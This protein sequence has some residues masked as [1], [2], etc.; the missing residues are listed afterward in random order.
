MLF[1]WLIY[2]NNTAELIRE[3]KKGMFV[4]DLSLYIADEDRE[5]AV[6]RLNE[7]LQRIY[8]WSIVNHMM[9][10]HEK[11]HVIDTGQGSRRMKD[12]NLKQVLFG[13]DAR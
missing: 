3:S 1:A 11:F 13:Y 2:I 4:D 6:T 5:R 8:N 12:C 7:G 9:F 10:S